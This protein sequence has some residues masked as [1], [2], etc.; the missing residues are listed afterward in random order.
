MMKMEVFF[1][2]KMFTFEIRKE[3]EKIEGRTARRESRNS[4][5]RRPA[6]EGLDI[7]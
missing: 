6:A 1:F 7:V 3:R 2:S 4:L 5:S